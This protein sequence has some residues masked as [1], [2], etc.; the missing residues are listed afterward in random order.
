MRCRRP[1][2]RRSIRKNRTIQTNA[3]K[4]AA[5]MSTEASPVCGARLLRFGAPDWLYDG[6]GIGVARQPQLAAHAI[7]DRLANVG[8]VLEELFCVLPPLAKALARIREP[9]AAFFDN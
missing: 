2:K 7:L 5:F 6:G 3:M 4:N 8:I 9:G 1:R